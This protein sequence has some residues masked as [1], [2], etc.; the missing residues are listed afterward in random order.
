MTSTKCE[1]ARSLLGAVLESLLE[2]TTTAGGPSNLNVGGQNT[3]S[4]GAG[5]GPAVSS[6]AQSVP[7][8][9]QSLLS[10]RTASLYSYMYEGCTRWHQG[11]M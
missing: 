6:L 7:T 10:R 5:L 11:S 1:E 8:E 2:L 9:R 4:T 3:H